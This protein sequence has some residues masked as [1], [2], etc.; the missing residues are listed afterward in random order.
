MQTANTAY[1]IAPP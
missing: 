1:G